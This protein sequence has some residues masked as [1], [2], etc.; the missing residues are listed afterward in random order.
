MIDIKE[1]VKVLF[2]KHSAFCGRVQ[3]DI[4]ERGENFA[5]LTM[6]NDKNPKFPLTVMV[7]DKG[8]SLVFVGNSGEA[9]RCESEKSLI[10]TLD[11]VISNRVYFTLQ[12]RNDA[13]FDVCR[14]CAGR[15][16]TDAQEHKKYIESLESKVGFFEKLL[17]GNTGI[18]ETTDFSG[19]SYRI[20]RRGLKERN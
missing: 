8:Y 18:F 2:R 19:T 9:L 16:D 7:Y 13:D 17:G 10:Q 15:I 14:V 6:P 20:I 3:Y 12:Y 5:T 11:D 4:S 1:T